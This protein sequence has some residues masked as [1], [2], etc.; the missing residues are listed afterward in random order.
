MPVHKSKTMIAVEALR[1]KII[2]GEVEPGQ[3]FDVKRLAT[4]FDM[5]ITP[6]REALRI[7][8]ADGLVSYDEHRSISA[9]QLSESDAMELYLL[10]ATLESMAAGMAA[11]RWL[12]IDEE[13][14]KAAH[15]EMVDA[16]R[17][18]DATRASAA[19]RAWHFAVYDSARSHFISPIISRLWSQ[20]AWSAVWSVPGRLENSLLE[21]EA[22]TA[23][24]LARDTERAA[25]LMRQ[26]VE[27]G[28][29]AVIKHGENIARGGQGVV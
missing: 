25:A 14:V 7:L 11:E 16:V 3:R 2:K 5:S 17:A 1:D 22:I 29:H 13:K 18:G 9:M 12:P 20:F 28:Q 23:A 15:A 24:Y 6:V 10:R 26:H 27:G 19:N 4:E 21:H 8:Q